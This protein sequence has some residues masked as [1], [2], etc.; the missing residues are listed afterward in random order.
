MA[1]REQ[2]NIDM[3]SNEETLMDE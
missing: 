1:I 2:T 3:K